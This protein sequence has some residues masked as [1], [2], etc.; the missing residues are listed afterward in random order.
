MK[1]IYL[2]AALAALSFVSCQKE[3]PQEKIKSITVNTEILPLTKASVED[4]AAAVWSAGESAALIS[5]SDFAVKGTYSLASEDI[6]SDGGKA[7][8]SYEAFSGN[9]RLISPEPSSVSADGVVFSI[10][11]SQTQAELGISGSRACLVGG[12]KGSDGLLSDIVVD[13]K[14]ASYDASFKLAGAILQFVVFDSSNPT[15]E[16]IKSLTVTAADAK[17]NGNVTVDYDGNVKS[18]SGSGNSTTVTVSN[19]EIVVSDKAS[20]KGIYLTAVPAAISANDAGSVTYTV[21]T[22]GSVYEF[23]SKA[24]KTWTAGVVNVEEIDLAAATRIQ[25]QA[26]I[27]SSTHPYTF[28]DFPMYEIEPGVYSI[29]HV[30]LSGQEKDIYFPAGTSGFYYNPVDPWVASEDIEFDLGFSNEPVALKVQQWGGKNYTEK[31]YTIILNTNTM[32]LQVLQDRGERFWI[33][34]D[35]L[36]WDLKKYEMDVDKA[37]GKATWSGYLKTGEFK[38]HGETMWLDNDGNFTWNGPDSQNGSGEWYF[39]DDSRENG[40]SMNSADDNKWTVEAGYYSLEFNYKANPMTFIITRKDKLDLCVNGKSLNYSGNNDYEI[41]TEFTKG[42][43]FVLSGCNNLEY[44]RM[45]PDFIKDGKFNAITGTYKFILHLQTHDSS[46]NNG[47]AQNPTCSWTMFKG[48][49]DSYGTYSTLILAGNGVASLTLNNQ[50]GWSVSHPYQPFMAEIEDNVFQFTGRF[51]GPWEWCE[52]YDRWTWNLDFKYFGDTNWGWGIP[53]G[54]N[55]VDNTG[56]LHQ[57]G[58]G[59]LTWSNSDSKWDDGSI[60]RMTVNRNT[61]PHTVTFDKL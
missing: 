30:W 46:W 5:M 42:E 34:G 60:Y 25:R 23:E 38:I 36:S 52:P 10:P 24:A 39:E 56:K 22:D 27:M 54:V 7:C 6:S 44:V 58:E 57:T 61:N 49:T 17:L 37:A 16:K 20:A 35:V 48:L 53:N 33:T 18:V 47:E 12:A 50:C 13:S 1:K 15:G 32:K 11:A 28:G 41:E 4:G 55:L 3:D 40:I 26:P 51:K 9:Y 43:E 2:V 59:N 19:P 21:V 45:D 31:Y 29:E 8:F 14:T